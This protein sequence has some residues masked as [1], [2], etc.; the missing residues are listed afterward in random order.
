MG[1]PRSLVILSQ[2]ERMLAE[3]RDLDDLKMVRDLALAAAQYARAQKLGRAAQAH[4]VEIAAVASRRM[5][6]VD[7]PTR[8]KRGGAMSAP[9]DIGKQR[10]SENRDLLV[11]DEAEVREEV[12]KLKDP[13]LSRIRRIARDRKARSRPVTE[14]PVLPPDCD[15][16]PGD[17]RTAL[18]DVADQSVD[19]IL[20]DPPYPAE[21]LPLWDDLGAFAARVLKPTGM[22]AAMSGQANLPDVYAKLGAHLPYRWTIAYLMPGAAAVVHPR[23][24]STMWKPVLVYGATD[25]R[26]HDVVASDAGDKAYHGWGQSESGMLALIRQLAEPGMLVCDP[27]VGGGTTALA[28]LRYGCSFIGAEIDPEA[29]ETALA[30]L[31]TARRAS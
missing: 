21:F 5:A 7:P 29:H 25:R 10:R 17:F 22:L 11:L 6:E 15:I 13:S 16:R 8:Y 31:D 1:E 30:R 18:A 23:R 20:T 9:A 26:F 4:A 3:A 12:R 2:G 28:A 27:F 19:L 14:P 24:V